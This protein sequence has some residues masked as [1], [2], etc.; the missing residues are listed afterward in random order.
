MAPLATSVTEPPG[1]TEGDE[2]VSVTLSEVPIPMVITVAPRQ[3]PV[4]PITVYVVAIVGEATTTGPDVVFN[5]GS[6]TQV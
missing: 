2:A 1:H 5:D 6:G 3:L 4:C